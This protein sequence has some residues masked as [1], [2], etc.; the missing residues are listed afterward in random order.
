[1]VC[2]GAYV[3]CFSCCYCW[4]SLDATADGRTML[5]ECAD[6]RELIVRYMKR[7][8][9]WSCLM[10]KWTS[11]PTHCRRWP[12]R[13]LRLRRNDHSQTFGSV[14]EMLLL[15]IHH[16]SVVLLTFPL[17]EQLPSLAL[18][19]VLR[20]LGKY[21]IPVLGQLPLVPVGLTAIN[22]PLATLPRTLKT[23]S[24]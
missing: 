1:V 17:Q 18:G 22:L 9:A 24:T 2:C 20:S 12:R 13:S 5:T 11:W 7:R 8:T 21:L 19:V 14:Y 23:Y 15:L 3:G 4:V 10:L 6:S 16:V